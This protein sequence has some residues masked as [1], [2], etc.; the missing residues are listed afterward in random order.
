MRG[1][2]GIFAT[3]GVIGKGSVFLP[4]EGIYATKS[5]FGSFPN[6]QKSDV[7]EIIMDKGPNLLL[8][9]PKVL[10]MG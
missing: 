9:P 6:A 8:I 3:G 10:I 7:I 4:S 2:K 1:Q 5:E